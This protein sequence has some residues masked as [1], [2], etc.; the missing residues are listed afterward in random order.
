M[1]GISSLGSFNF[2]TRSNHADLIAMVSGTSVDQTT[3]DEWTQY[4][5][6]TLQRDFDEFSL[7]ITYRIQ[8]FESAT[9]GATKF[10]NMI[11]PRATIK[12]M[13]NTSISYQTV[14]G[15]N[16]QVSPRSS[17]RS[18]NGVP[19]SSNLGA[20]DN[21]V[22]MYNIVSD[23]PLWQTTYV[24]DDTSASIVGSYQPYTATAGTASSTKNLVTTID[25]STLV[26]TAGVADTVTQASATFAIDSG[27]TAGDI[28]TVL[29]ETQYVAPT[30]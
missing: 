16:F 4:T 1:Y 24:A 28:V 25:G 7:I 10:L 20:T 21:L 14:S 13:G 27:L 8:S 11:V 17:G 23:Y 2:Q 15:Y 29:Y 26:A 18:I 12:A 9:F 30:S 19:F 22:S 6:N 5:E 3:N